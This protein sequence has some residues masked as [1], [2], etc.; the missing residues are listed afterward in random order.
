MFPGCESFEPSDLRQRHFATTHW[1]VVLAASPGNMPHASAALEH[2]CRT[3][4]Y[5]VYAF[6]RRHGHSPVDAEDSTQE[7]F[8]RLMQK[9][10]MRSPRPE[11]GKFRWYLLAAVRH[12]LANEWD[13]ATAQKRGG[14]VTIIP[15]DSVAAEERYAG[16]PRCESGAD[17]LYDRTWALTL[18]ADARG[19]LEDEFRRAGKADR[20]TLLETLLPGGDGHLDQAKAAE[21]LGLTPGGLR[22]EVHRFKRR[23][24][25]LLRTAVAHTVAEPGDIDG[26][27]QYLIEIMSTG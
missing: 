7:F 14:G 26:E 27:L 23:F 2:L 22:S 9:G 13:R 6:V 16:E 15:W 12:F 8:T 19:R 20:F 17:R 4:W 18:L 24:G 10:S 21:Q 5:P 1:S 11:R 3:Y 25:E